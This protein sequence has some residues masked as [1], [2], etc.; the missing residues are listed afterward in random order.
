MSVQQK[1]A[2]L[3]E[4]RALLVEEGGL[5]IDV[6]FPIVAMQGRAHEENHLGYCHGTHRQYVQTGATRKISTANKTSKIAIRLFV[7]THDSA[8]RPI[9]KELSLLALIPTFLHELAHSITPGVLIYGQDPNDQKG[10]RSRKWYFDAHGDLFYASFAK[11]LQ[12]AEQL[13]IYERPRVQGKFMPRQLRRFDSIDL[14]VAPVG[15]IGSSPRYGGTFEPTIVQAEQK[16]DGAAP[17][18]EPPV[19]KGVVTLEFRGVK[20]PVRLPWRD[21]ITRM[22]LLHAGQQKFRCKAT[23]IMSPQGAELSDEQL[24]DIS[25]GALLVLA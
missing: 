6:A 17:A 22:I 24:A 21:D 23:R 12:V 5:D 19:K 11:I 25:P 2:V 3:S 1:L 8:G 16:S 18:R 15:Q 9:K 14:A 13:G 4:I 20:K 10:K 7:E